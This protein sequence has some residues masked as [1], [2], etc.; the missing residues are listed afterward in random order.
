MSSMEGSTRAGKLIIAFGDDDDD[1][2]ELKG[3]ER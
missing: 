2:G 1:D 3:A